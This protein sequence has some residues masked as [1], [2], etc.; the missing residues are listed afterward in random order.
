MRRLE[1]VVDNRYQLR[2]R[3]WKDRGLQQAI[4][5]VIKGKRNIRLGI[6][7]LIAGGHL[8]AEDVPGVGKPLAHALACALHCS[9]SAS[10]LP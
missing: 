10:S 3:R 7:A 2:L 1:P 5:T 9:F 6:A 4:E 8:L